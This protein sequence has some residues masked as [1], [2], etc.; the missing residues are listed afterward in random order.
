MAQESPCISNF[1]S[2]TSYVAEKMYYGVTPL[3]ATVFESF[4]MQIGLSLSIQEN[5]VLVYWEITKK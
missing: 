1:K 4:Y 2:L 5:I 3:I